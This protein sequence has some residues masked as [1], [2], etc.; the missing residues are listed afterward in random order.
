MERKEET[1]SIQITGT[2]AEKKC[3]IRV[4]YQIKKVSF[5][6][7]ACCCCVNNKF[8]FTLFIFITSI[9]VI[10]A[11]TEKRAIFCFAFDKNANFTIGFHRSGHTKLSTEKN[12]KNSFFPF[13]HSILT[14][15]LLDVLHFH[16]E[17]ILMDGMKYTKHLLGVLSYKNLNLLC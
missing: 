2:N 17:T 14:S 11:G 12:K 15:F 5:F 10:F 1:S 16:I 9:A 7:A 3:R 8:S 6:S 13:R 4:F